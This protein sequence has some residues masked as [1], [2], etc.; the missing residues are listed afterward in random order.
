MTLPSTCFR[1][2]FFQHIVYSHYSAHARVVRNTRSLL[3]YCFDTVSRSFFL[4]QPGPYMCEASRGSAVRAKPGIARGARIEAAAFC[5]FLK[6]ANIRTEAG[7]KQGGFH[8]INLPPHPPQT[9]LQSEEAVFQLEIKDFHLP[10]ENAGRLHFQTL[11]RCS[12]LA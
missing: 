3:R 2:L 12:R 11:Q 1:L 5:L 8:S 4:A 7:Q 10:D 9:R 6:Q